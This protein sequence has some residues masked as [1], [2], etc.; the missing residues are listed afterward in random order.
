MSKCVVLGSFRKHYSDIVAVV[1][2]FRKAGLEVL[3]P[4]A[5][6]IIN[7][8]GEFVILRSDLDAC[9]S[10]DVK[11]I[12]DRVLEAIGQSE[13]AYVC[14]PEGYTGLTVSFEI[15]F[16][17]ASGTHVFSMCLISDVTLRRYV[18][19][20]L[21]PEELIDHVLS[22]NRENSGVGGREC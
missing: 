6:V 20:V 3:S 22:V 17:Q 8:G 14:N 2:L 4:A 7:P 10:T 1:T 19:R 21:S 15:G 16:A 11:R 18:D 12:Q 13:F 9:S 5:S